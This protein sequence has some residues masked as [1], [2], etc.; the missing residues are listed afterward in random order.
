MTAEALNSIKSK[1][2]SWAQ[3]CATKLTAD[4]ERYKRI[5]NKANEDIRNAKRNFE[6]KVAKKAKTESKHFWKYVKHKVKTQ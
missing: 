6:R 3:Y 2:H 4:F 1:R 5:R